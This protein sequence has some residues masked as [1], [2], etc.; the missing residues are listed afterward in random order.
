MD[1]L[2]GRKHCL[3]SDRYAVFAPF[4]TLL[5]VDGFRLVYAE[6]LVFQVELLQPSIIYWELEQTSNTGSSSVCQ[7]AEDQDS[8]HVTGFRIIPARPRLAALCVQ[9]RQFDFDL[10][11][12]DPSV[13]FRINDLISAFSDLVRCI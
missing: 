4:S 11:H 7:S 13:S 10:M 3:S 1:V 12:L 8:D 9:A 5:N 6:A 2:P